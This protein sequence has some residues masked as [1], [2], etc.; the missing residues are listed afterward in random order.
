MLAVNGISVTYPDGN[1]ALDSVSFAIGDNERVALIG[2]NGAG[3]STLL[4]A[5]VGL[6]PMSGEISVCGVKLSKQT[7]SEI[8]KII[9]IVFQNPDD[10]LFTMKVRDDIAF[11]PRNFGLSDEEAE[12]LVDSALEQLNAVH[13]KERTPYKLS[14][15][16]KRIVGIAA[17]LAMNPKVLLLDE[18]SSFQDPRSR[19]ILIGTLRSL[20]QA[21]LVAT[22]DLDLARSLCSRVIVLR[23]GRVRAEGPTDEI[24]SD[25]GRLEEYGL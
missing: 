19:R 21:Q 24:L 1:L 6:L 25:D 16:E 12:R 4:R 13:L 22:H 18:P 20:R 8:R 17:I 2:A 11:G 5:I 9:G 15:G 23:D 7:A 14:A 3:K 10:Q